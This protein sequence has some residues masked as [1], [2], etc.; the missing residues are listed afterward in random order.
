MSKTLQFVQKTRTMS[1]DYE[2][3]VKAILAVPERHIS[4]GI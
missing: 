3:I 2:E 1:K 4:R